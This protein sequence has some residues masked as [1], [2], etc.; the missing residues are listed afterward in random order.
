M[1]ERGLQQVYF[2]LQQIA[3]RLGDEEARR[4][5]DLVPSVL[6]VEPLPRDCGA[7]T[8]GLDALLGAVHLTNSLTQRLGNLE[9][10]AGDLLCGLPPLNLRARQSGFFVAASERI[11]HGEAD[12]PRRIRA[13]EHLSQHAAVAPSGGPDDGSG[14]LARSQKP[15]PA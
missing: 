7:G 3:L 12:T 2:G 4:Q 10:H 9:L 5:P 6:D 8:R 15:R 13:V 1:I 14:E 11:A